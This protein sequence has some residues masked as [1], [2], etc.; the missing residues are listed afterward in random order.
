MDGAQDPTSAI[1]MDSAHHTRPD[2]GD[3]LS[4]PESTGLSASGIIPHA[5]VTHRRTSTNYPP[6]TIPHRLVEPVI[7]Q[8]ERYQVRYIMSRKDI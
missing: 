8:V 6:H 5:S 3:M 2:L 7:V 4:T 1:R